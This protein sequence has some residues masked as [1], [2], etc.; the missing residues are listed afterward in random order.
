MVKK[1]AIIGAG[2]IGLALGRV[3]RAKGCQLK[4]WDKNPQVLAL[5]GGGELGVREV[6]AE[7]EAVFMCVPSWAMREAL[8]CVTPYLPKRAVVISLSKGIEAATLKRMDELLKLLLAKSQPWGLLSGPMLA[9]EISEG[10][11]G[12]GVIVSSS[13]KTV[14]AIKELF[15]GTN[16][17]G[18]ISTDVAGVALSGV[19]KNIYALALGVAAGLKLGDNARGSL[20]V[21]VLAEMKKI[22]ALLGGKQETVMGP[23]GLGDL[24]ATGFSAHSKNN[25]V[26]RELAARKVS[27]LASE[28]LASLSSVI[29]LLGDKYKKFPILRSLSEI[30]QGNIEA[31]PAFQEILYKK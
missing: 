22:V 2:E 11:F 8:L 31:S 24:I 1:I 4:F 18:Q 16:L 30:V 6:V 21:L 7:A 5:L 17:V 14:Q 28:G 20:I 19:L 13:P 23:A 26:G 15:T 12:A 3:L 27:D 10:M 25:E 9:E 29:I